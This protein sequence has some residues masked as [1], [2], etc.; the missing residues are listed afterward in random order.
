ME[1]P[2]WP[3]KLALRSLPDGL[4]NHLLSRTFNHFLNGQRFAQRLSYLNGKRL[5]LTINDTNN[6]WHFRINKGQ[7]VP[8]HLQAQPEIH[9]KGDFK[10]FI[11]LATRNEDPDTLF[12]AR[13]I[14]IEGNT[15]DSLY[16]KNLLDAMEF[17]TEAHFKAF[18][19]EA[20]GLRL[21]SL[22]NR[23]NAG[24]RL[25]RFGAKYIE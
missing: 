2:T 3:L 5:W 8:D 9:I 24:E 20:L 6:S 21:A 25:Q 16:L 19:G 7:F 18:I 23:T 15:E 22:F 14:S 4:H 1:L 10:H 13:Q 11:L 17:D 12:F